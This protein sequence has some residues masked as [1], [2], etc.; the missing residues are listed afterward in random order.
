MSQCCH[1]E[2]CLLPQSYSIYGSRKSVIEEPFPVVIQNNGARFFLHLPMKDV[3]SITRKKIYALKGTKTKHLCNNVHAPFKYETRRCEFTYVCIY[4]FKC[5]LHAC[6][7][8]E[9]TIFMH[10]MF[11]ALWMQYREQIN[12]NFA[13]QSTSK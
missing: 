2:K 9:F 10:T 5:T 6:I 13:K 12:T 11:N 3:T 8:A 4:V 1:I 7:N